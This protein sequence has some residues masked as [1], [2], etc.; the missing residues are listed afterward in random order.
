[1]F[2]LYEVQVSGNLQYDD[3]RDW[4]IYYN[5]SVE[6]DRLQICDVNFE[7]ETIAKTF[8]SDIQDFPRYSAFDPQTVPK[9]SENTE[10]ELT[11]PSEYRSEPE[12]VPEESTFDTIIQDIPYNSVPDDTNTKEVTADYL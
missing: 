1:M 10:H 5:T 4:E 12:D 3:Q 8:S 6:E 9:N 2:D 11:L 7:L